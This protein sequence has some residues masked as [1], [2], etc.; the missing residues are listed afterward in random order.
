MEKMDSP[1]SVPPESDSSDGA[2]ASNEQNE[3]HFF[4]LPREL[5]DMISE[6]TYPHTDEISAEYGLLYEFSVGEMDIIS[7]RIRTSLE[8]DS[9][10]VSWSDCQRTQGVTDLFR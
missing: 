7:K 9:A 6:Y 1:L 5:R 2:N 10:A 8:P 3:C 4:Q